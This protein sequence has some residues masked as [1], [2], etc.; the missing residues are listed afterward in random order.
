[1]GA[2]RWAFAVLLR[3]YIEDTDVQS[4]FHIGTIKVYLIITLM[5]D[6]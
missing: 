6:S 4:K 3:F 1:M 2:L 5:P